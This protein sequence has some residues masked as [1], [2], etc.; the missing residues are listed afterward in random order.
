MTVAIEKSRAAGKVWAPP[1]KSVAHRA[2]ICGSLGGGSTISNVDYSN[3]ISATLDCLKILGADVKKD[4]NTVTLGGLNPFECKAATLDCQESGS[5]LRFLIPLCMLSGAN[6]T[7]T[8]SRRLFERN[9]DIYSQIAEQND[10]TFKKTENSL[11]ICGKLRSGDYKIAGNISSQFISGLLFALPLLSGD[12]TLEII[13]DYES[14]P[15]VDLTLKE[16]DDFGV[17]I[18]KDGRIYKIK[19]KQRYSSQIKSVEGDYSNAAFLDGF[20]LLGGCVEVL[21]LDKNSLQGDR[22]YKSM[23]ADLKSGK[24]QFDLSN[25]PDLAPV[26]FALAAYFGGAHFTG[27]RRLKIKESDR[28][29]AMAAELA[30]F[31]INV[32]VLDNDVII[33]GGKLK[34]PSAVLD[35]HNDHRIVMALSL[36]CSVTGGTISG[37]EAVAK[38]YPDYF[39]KIKSIKVVV[40][41][42]T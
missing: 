27:T 13:G 10:I 18:E 9:L 5:T 17:K 28:A 3:D 4:G 36:L 22:I 15:Y 16:L 21:G 20:N 12:S 31:G 38:S 41:N 29:A 19:G 14:E 42:E 33:N 39:E 25:C 23:F 11:S 2:L 34:T 8:G 1:S 32:D 7:L 26:M 24:R 35:G 6:I 30:K 37:T 40:K